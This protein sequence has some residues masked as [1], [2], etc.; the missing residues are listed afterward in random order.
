MTPDRILVRAMALDDEYP[1]DAVLAVVE[2]VNTLREQLWRE[3]E[4]PEIAWQIYYADFYDAQVKNGGHSQFFYNANP[5]ESVARLARGGLLLVGAKE[6]AAIL[7]AAVALVEKSPGLLEQLDETGYFGA[8]AE[9][10]P[11]FESLDRALFA[12]DDQAGWASR[13]RAWMRASPAVEKLDE[14][15][16]VA[17]MRALRGAVPDREDR[18]REAAEA[19]EASMPAFERFIRDACGDRGLAYEGLTAG[20]PGEDGSMTWSFFASGARRE[21]V[22]QP[23][24]AVTEIRWDLV[25]SPEEQRM[26]ELMRSLGDHRES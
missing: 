1:D 22:V 11:S 13:C 19:R 8:A 2:Y 17:R 12:I 23:S 26:L 6:Q 10:A 9:V 5:R 25:M 4:I 3:E 16:Y 20:R 15:V 18:E 24:G 7:D 14:A 21:A